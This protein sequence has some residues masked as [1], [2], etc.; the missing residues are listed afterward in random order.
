MALDMEAV[1]LSTAQPMWGHAASFWNSRSSPQFDPAKAPLTAR[2]SAPSFLQSGKS[3]RFRWSTS[4]GVFNRRQ[5]Q[6]NRHRMSTTI[7]DGAQAPESAVTKP[8]G[9]RKNGTFKTTYTA[10]LV[11]H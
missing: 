9:M 3:D 5:P 11:P 2:N 1:G 4:D 10:F 7:V 8:L 6:F